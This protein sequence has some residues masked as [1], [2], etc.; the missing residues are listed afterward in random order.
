M[1]AFK[2]PVINAGNAFTVIWLT[3]VHPV[4]NVKVILAV[5]APMPV[6]TPPELMVATAPLLLFQVPDPDP[7][8]NVVVLPAHNVDDPVI[9]A[10]AGFTV[11]AFV[12]T[13]PFGA[14]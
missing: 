10:G 8:V 11:T 2:V 9:V 5:P 12:A 14:V 1:Q 3:A 13:Q 6:T 7:S 4:G